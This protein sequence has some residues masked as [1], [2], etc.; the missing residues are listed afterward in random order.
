VTQTRRSV[1]PRT[2]STAHEDAGAAAPDSGLDEVAG[3]IVVEHALHRALQL[4]HALGPDHRMRARGPVD[5]GFARLAVEGPQSDARPL[6]RRIVVD[7]P[8]EAIAQQLEIDLAK[9]FGRHRMV[10]GHGAVGRC[11]PEHS[12]IEI[13]RYV[14]NLPCLHGTPSTPN[15]AA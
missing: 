15:P 12:T 4:E 11:G 2:L 9:L 8:S 3:D 7:E 6:E 1:T 14:P 13:L 10:G 5:A